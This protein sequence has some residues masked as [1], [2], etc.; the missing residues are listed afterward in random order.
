LDV[1]VGVFDTVIGYEVFETLA[2]PN[3]SRS[4]G[5][6]LE[7]T[8]HTGVLAT[9]QL[10]SWLNVSAGV[11]NTYTG[12]INSRPARATAGGIDL[13]SESEKTYLGSITITVPESAGA[14]AGSTIYA[15]IV[16]GLNG[17]GAG[18]SGHDITSY[19][20]GATV[21]T[22]LKGLSVGIGYDYRQ[23]GP[24]VTGAGLDQDNR[25]YALAGYLSFALTEKFKINGRVDYVNA[26]NGTFY[27]EPGSGAVYEVKHSS[28]HEKLLGSTLTFD[29]SLWDNVLTRAELRWDHSLTGD[30]PYGNADEKNAVS[31]AANI[32]YKF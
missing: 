4:Y 24:P 17:L 12:F 27:G 2:N 22:G 25:S 7:P 23:D 9:Y 11:A 18:A 16:D 13:A 32:I 5:Y 19:Y 14:L 21:N 30:R 20:G 31:L 29:Y 10:L 6:A 1:K 8:H 26:A 3:Y 28:S 15:G